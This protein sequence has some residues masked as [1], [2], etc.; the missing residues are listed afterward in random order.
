VIRRLLLGVTGSAAAFKGV[1]L[2]SDLSKM[3][4]QV[5]A[6]LTEAGA[7]FVGPAQLASV[8]GR[9][10]WTDLFGDGGDH[11]PH[12]TL[13]ESADLLVVAPATADIMA[14]LAMGLA[15]DLLSSTAMAFRGP[16][17]LAPAMNHRMWQ[18]PAV[19]EN[20]RRLK[21]R[22]AVFAGPVEG[23]MACGTDGPGRMM[24]PREVIEVVEGALRG[25]GEGR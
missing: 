2:A 3:G 20:V 15:D 4:Y 11:M 23:R 24:E 17:V 13:S 14:K 19:M 18:S 5:D 1:A 6:I 25:H 10:V 16:L 9:K 7:R 12:I 22:G 21:E 8:T